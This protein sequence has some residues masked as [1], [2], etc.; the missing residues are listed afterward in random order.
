MILL[1]ST[2]GPEFRRS[3]IIRSFTD[4]KVESASHEKEARMQLTDAQQGISGPFVLDGEIYGKIRA[5]TIASI[6][7]E[8]TDKKDFKEVSFL[9]GTIHRNYAQSFERIL[10]RW[11]LGNV[12]VRMFDLQDLDHNFRA[13][14]YSYPNTVS[15]R[16]IMKEKLTARIEDMKAVLERSFQHRDKVLQ[17]TAQNHGTWFIKYLNAS[18]S[19]TGDSQDICKPFV[20]LKMKATFSALNCFN[21]DVTQR[22]LIAEGWA[23]TEELYL[24]KLALERGMEVSGSIIAPVINEMTTTSVPPTFNKVNKFTRSYQNIVDAYGVANYQEINPTPWTII[25]FPFIFAI[26]FGDAGHGL[27][28]FFLAL[29]LII[30]E[31]RFI[32]AKIKDEI[33]N[34]FFGGRYVILLMGLFSALY[35]TI[36]IPNLSI[37]LEAAGKTLTSQEPSLQKDLNGSGDL[38]LPPGYA[39][40]H[41]KVSAKFMYSKKFFLK[42]NITFKDSFIMHVNKY[43]VDNGPYPFGV[44]PVWSI[45]VNKLNYLNP[46]KMKMSVIVGISQMTFGLALALL[47]HMY[48][49]RKKLFQIK[50]GYSFRLDPS[51]ALPRFYLCLPLHTGLISFAFKTKHESDKQLRFQIITKWIMY[52]V[53]PQFIF[54]Y[55][56]PSSNCAP[57]LLIGLINMFMMKSRQAG[58][59]DAS[60]GNCSEYL[61]AI[62]NQDCTTSRISVEC[63]NAVK[64]CQP[65]AECAL[66]QWYPNQYPQN[67]FN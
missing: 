4:C 22:C 35:T 18:S 16:K 59:V 67:G 56:Y 63:S 23:P 40:E 11:C 41:E 3:R 66:N 47:N 43:A 14:V 36:F 38:T 46:L 48:A 34:I 53:W 6:E 20:V 54:G 2:Y 37:F 8:I 27:I 49:T 32:A 28:M 45:S 39:F 15:E 52:Y 57:T 61:Q 58:F 13:K 55:F 7:S 25:T 24:I 5:S 1:I 12:F 30:Y 51:T 62:K 42:C 33:F 10:W 64:N 17:A 26:M 21:F 65:Y 9:A 60:V 50:S 19:I 44:D 31:K 29:I